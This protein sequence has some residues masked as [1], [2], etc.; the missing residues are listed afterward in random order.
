MKVQAI[1][2]SAVGSMMNDL[3]QYDYDTKVNWI[4]VFTNQ[5]CKSMLKFVETFNDASGKLSTEIESI[6]KQGAAIDEETKKAK[7]LLMSWFDS[8][9]SEEEK[10]SAYKWIQDEFLK[11]E[12][13]SKNAKNNLVEKLKE[14]NSKEYELSEV[15]IKMEWNFDS[16]P[17]KILWAV[18]FFSKK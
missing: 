10:K 5:S 15:L 14:V 11:I 13:E 16:L 12:E 3:L 2:L 17:A 9:E 1:W 4:K 7:D 8:F 18:E 6:K